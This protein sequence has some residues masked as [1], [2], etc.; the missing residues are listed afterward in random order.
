MTAKTL[1]TPA[2]IIEARNR[3]YVLTADQLLARG[4]VNIPAILAEDATY[5]IVL[6]GY[7]NM[8]RTI[9]EVRA[10]ALVPLAEARALVGTVPNVIVRGLDHAEA[11]AVAKRFREA[12][13]HVTVKR[14]TA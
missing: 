2:E 14:V 6:T 4:F 12:G 9:N 8:I 1:F 11:W 7:A 10:Q 5:D 3:I 13:A